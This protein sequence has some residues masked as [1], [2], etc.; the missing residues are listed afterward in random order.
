[1]DKKE[2][3]IVMVDDSPAN[4]DLLTEMLDAQNYCVQAFPRGAMALK[5]AAQNPP[6]LIRLDTEGV[7]ALVRYFAQTQEISHG[8]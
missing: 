8:F 1:M 7:V 2:S 6:D 4:L 3:T 5:A